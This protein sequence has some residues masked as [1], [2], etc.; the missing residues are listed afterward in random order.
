MGKTKTLQVTPKKKHIYTEVT[1]NKFT[2]YA[3]P[4]WCKKENKAKPKAKP[5]LP[6]VTTFYLMKS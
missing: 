4:D 1:V 2:H 5:F 3:I 6:C